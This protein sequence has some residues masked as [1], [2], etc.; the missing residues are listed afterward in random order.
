MLW[1]QILVGTLKYMCIQERDVTEWRK[2]SEIKNNKN[3]D[4]KIIYFNFIK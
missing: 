1:I 2:Y 4:N 3:A